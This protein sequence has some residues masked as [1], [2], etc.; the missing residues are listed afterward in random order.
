MPVLAHPGPSA[1]AAPGVAVDH[2]AGPTA[3]TAREHV[4]HD[5]VTR[6]VRGAGLDAAAGAVQGVLDSLVPEEDR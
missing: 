5:D 1:P 6:R 3:P 4:R 2:R